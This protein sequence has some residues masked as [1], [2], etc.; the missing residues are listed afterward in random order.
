VAS[1]QAT[2][3][4]AIG[5]IGAAL[6]SIVRSLKRGVLH[7]FLLAQARID[8]DQAGLAILYVLHVAGANLRLCDLADQLRI[9]APAVTRKAQQ[10]E[11]SGL[12]SRTPDRLDARATRIQLTVQGR[13]TISRFLAA[14]RAWLTTVLAGWTDAEQAELGRLLRR[15]ADDIGRQVSEL[16]D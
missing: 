14:R 9:D 7:E 11:R 10:L 3:A 13:R 5:E 6:N 1:D 2:Q 4:E 12:V 8:A 16:D 15:F